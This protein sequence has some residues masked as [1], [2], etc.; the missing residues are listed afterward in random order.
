MQFD[1]NRNFMQN[2]FSSHLIQPISLHLSQVEE[3][4]F[5]LCVYYEWLNKFL[6]N[7]TLVF[8]FA[9]QYCTFP[10]EY[11]SPSFTTVKQAGKVLP[12]R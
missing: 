8:K 9:L 6:W 4:C 1:A 5:V 7:L 12:S 3:S 11:H 10:F 2:V